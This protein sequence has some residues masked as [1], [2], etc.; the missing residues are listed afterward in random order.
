MISQKTL[1]AT[2]SCGIFFILDV[3]LSTSFEKQFCS[4]FQ[5]VKGF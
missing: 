1:S 2:A 4:P 5:E 3:L